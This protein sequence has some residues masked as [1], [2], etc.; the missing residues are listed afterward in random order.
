MTIAAAYPAR[1]VTRMGFALVVG[2][3]SLLGVLG[4]V[5]WHIQLAP[6]A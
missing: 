1:Y 6:D 5:V 3:G 2:V 4:L